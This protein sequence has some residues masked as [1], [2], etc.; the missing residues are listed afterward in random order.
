MPDYRAI[1]R[2]AAQRYG[3]DPH[4]FERQINAESG[5]NPNAGSGA[6]AVGIAQ[7][8][9][10]TAKGLG[11]DPRDPTQA[12]NG[13]AKLMAGYVK[14]YGGYENAL[15]AYNAGEG[16][17]KASHGYAETNAYVAK[18]LNGRN[19]GGLRKPGGLSQTLGTPAMSVA[20]SGVSGGQPI[21]L[22][23]AGSSALSQMLLASVNKP[24]PQLAGGQIASPSFS[25]DLKY[26]PAGG[27]VQPVGLG[28]PPQSGVADQLAALVAQQDTSLPSVSNTA[29]SATATGTIPATNGHPS[30]TPGHAAA[31]GGKVIVAGGANRGGVGLQEPILNFLHQVAAVSGR[32]VTV[33]TGTNHNQYVAGEP[34][35][36]SDH[37][38]GNASDLG[39]NGDARQSVAARKQGDLI[40]AHAIQVAA[41][42]PFQQAY[43]IAAAGGVH[44]FQTKAGRVQVLWKTMVGGNHFNHVHIGVE[45]GR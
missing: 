44:N 34:G 10:A 19:P 9:P 6:G 27:G 5:F 15:R 41:G 25:A 23:D 45:P 14:K 38:T 22:P 11:I 37:W 43:K 29:S 17:V 39:V 28:G 7:F 12:L 3:L 4:V 35:V 20:A 33:T 2:Q 36:Q 40:A 8:M 18:I 32:P 13:A 21:G 1:A 42:I 31:S 26:G 24:A 30:A 16:A